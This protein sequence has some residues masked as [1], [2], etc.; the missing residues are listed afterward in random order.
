MKKNI[1]ANR[2]KK[3]LLI[4]LLNLLLPII[5]LCLFE[6]TKENKN[7]I[8]NLKLNKYKQ[9]SLNLLIG[10]SKQEI[11]GIISSKDNNN[12]FISEKCLN[13][14]GNKKI[15]TESSQSLV[16]YNQ[17]IALEV[18]LIIFNIKNFLFK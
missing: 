9:F 7:Y 12:V 8:L 15:Q 18:I 13:C 5:F 2:N 16:E 1:L 11:N 17:K 14:S 3:I 4:S 10:S 6:K